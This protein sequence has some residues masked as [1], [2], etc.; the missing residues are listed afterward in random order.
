MKIYPVKYDCPLLKRTPSK[1]VEVNLKTYT[2][3]NVMKN[4]HF[5]SWNTFLFH[6]FDK[7]SGVITKYPKIGK[8][9][10]TITEK[11]LIKEKDFTAGL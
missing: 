6:V 2:A 9:M 10:M 11:M 5:N 1:P 8:K 3:E 4:T 7:M